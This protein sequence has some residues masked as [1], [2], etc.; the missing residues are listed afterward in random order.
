MRNKECY[1]RKLGYRVGSI[2]ECEWNRMVLGIEDIKRFLKVFFF[3]VY[4]G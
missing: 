1:P 3:S 2:W 4:G